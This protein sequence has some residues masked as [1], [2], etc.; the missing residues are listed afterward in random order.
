MPQ[1]PA[2]EAS[3]RPDADAGDTPVEREARVI[4]I[5]GASGLIGRALR[6]HLTREGQR[7][8]AL[9]RDPRAADADHVLWDPDADSQSLAALEGVHAVVHLA[10]ENVASRRWTDAQKRRIRES[11][12]VGTRNLSRALA[13]LE[14]PPSVLVS[15]SGIGFYGDHGARAVTEDEPPGSGFLS[16]VCIDWETAADP[17]RERGIRVVHP[18]IGLALAEGGGAL[19]RMLPIFR[20]GLGGKIGNGRQYLSWISLP[21]LVRVLAFAIDTPNLSGPVNAVAPGAVTNAELTRTLAHVLG[22]P[23]LLPV[24]APALKLALGE[25][26]TELLSSQRVE[27]ARLLAAG[28]QFLHPDLETALRAVLQREAR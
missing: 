10:G 22:R 6:E 2:S 27:P 5:T 25:L 21:D 28:F 18:R 11:R 24:P 8:V 9:V 15:A 16:Q 20:L 17:A 23:A 12:S 4:A 13:A 7:V 19:A 3:T 14:R 1:T 26:S